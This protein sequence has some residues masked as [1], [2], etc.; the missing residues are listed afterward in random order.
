LDPDVPYIQLVE[1]G[2]VEVG[3]F[4]KTNRLMEE[5]QLVVVRPPIENISASKLLRASPKDLAALDRSA[6]QSRPG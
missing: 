3:D 6:N 4:S 2:I 5:G 1:A